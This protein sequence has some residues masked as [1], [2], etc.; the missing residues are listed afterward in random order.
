MPIVTRYNIRCK[1][2]DD[3]IKEFKPIYLQKINDKIKA[4]PE[5]LAASALDREDLL[6]EFKEDAAMS[7]DIQPDCN[8]EVLFSEEQFDVT[9]DDALIDR[10]GYDAIRFYLSKKRGIHIIPADNYEHKM[11]EKLTDVGL[12]VRGESV[13]LPLLLESLKLK[14][15]SALVADLNPPKFTRKAKAVEYFNECD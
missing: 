1:E 14:E 5:W 8:L 11:F 10:F 3:Y 13:S 7:L 2:V 9:I 15:L 4:S 6:T 12:A